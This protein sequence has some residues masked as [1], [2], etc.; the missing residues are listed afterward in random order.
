MGAL[1]NRVKAA[2][3]NKFKETFSSH[4]EETKAQFESIHGICEDL[5]RHPT[6]AKCKAMEG[7]I[8]QCEG[9]IKEDTDANVKDG[10]F[11]A[12]GQGVEHYEIYGVWYCRSF[13]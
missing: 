13:C 9:M 6:S 12:C 2:S 3:D 7:L 5:N 1:P 11:I 10:G 8:A 4:L